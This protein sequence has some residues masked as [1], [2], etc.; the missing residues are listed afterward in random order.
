MLRPGTELP[1]KILYKPASLTSVPISFSWDPPMLIH[2][3]S[4]SASKHFRMPLKNSLLAQARSHR[5]PV[6]LQTLLM[7]LV[8]LKHL[9][10]LFH[11]RHSPLLSLTFIC[12]ESDHMTCLTEMKNRR[13]N[14]RRLPKRCVIGPAAGRLMMICQCSGNMLERIRSGPLCVNGRTA[15]RPWSRELLST[16]ISTLTSSP[17]YVL[18]AALDRQTR[19]TS[20]DTSWSMSLAS[21][22]APFR[23]ANVGSRD[24]SRHL[25]EQTMLPVTSERCI[26]TRQRAQ[27]VFQPQTHNNNRQQL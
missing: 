14:V 8:Q 6:E 11:Q 5:L 10:L 20:S 26:H 27:C 1:P 3:T 23:V 7:P 12:H 9:V 19:R 21:T 25:T 15:A 4:S 17:I 2:G 18:T 22:S 24:S 16:Y 13:Q